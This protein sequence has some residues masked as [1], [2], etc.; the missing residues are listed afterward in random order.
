MVAQTDIGKRFAHLCPPLGIRSDLEPVERFSHQVFHLPARI[1]RG[2]R[3][4]V[5]ELEMAPDRSERGLGSA[6]K[7]LAGHRDIAD[8]GSSSPRS[9]RIVV[10][11]PEPDSPTRACVVPARTEKDTSLTAVTTR[12]PTANRFV[13]PP[14][15][16]F[17]GSK[18]LSLRLRNPGARNAAYR[19]GFNA[20]T[21]AW[22]FLA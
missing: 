9:S 4:L 14:N 18:A 13:T 6:G 3:V 8:I 2:E 10:V 5:D 17:G 19:S 7:L 1:Q 22:S 15:A 12:P 21:S 16:I 20:G 11:L